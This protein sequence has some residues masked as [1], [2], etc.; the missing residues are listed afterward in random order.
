MNLEFDKGWIE[1]QAFREPRVRDV[2]TGSA[3]LHMI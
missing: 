3:V 2:S 1:I